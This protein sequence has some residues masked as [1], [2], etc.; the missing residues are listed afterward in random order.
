[1]NL[2]SYH[3]IF[4]RTK[5]IGRLLTAL[6]AFLIFHNGYGQ[7]NDITEVQMAEMVK[8]HSERLNKTIAD[9]SALYK[10]LIKTK[11]ILEQRQESKLLAK[12]YQNLGIW[13][14]KNISIDSVAYYYNKAALTYN[15]IGLPSQEAEIYLSLEDAYKKRSDYSSAMALDFKALRI[16]ENI[17]DQ[18]GIAKVYTRLCDIL[19]YQQEYR[20]GAEYCQ[21]AIII[22]SKLDQPVELAISYRYKADNLLI[23]K[24][25][26]E[27]L[28]NINQAI[29]VLEDANRSSVELAPNFNTRG[30]IYKYQERYKDAIEEYTRCYDIAKANNNYRGLISSLGNIGHVYRLQEKYKKALPYTLEA[31][32]LIKESGNTQNL[33]EN[34]M[35]TADSYKAIGDFEKSLTYER[36]FSK[37]KIENLS[38]IIDQLESELQIK[39]ETEKKDQTIESQEAKLERQKRIQQL[40][41]G[42]AFLL[43]VLLIGMYFYIRNNKKKRIALEKLNNK[44]KNKQ[45]QLEN[46]NSKLKASLKELK[47]TQEQLIQ[48]EKMAS[49]GELTAGIAHEIQNPLNFVNNFSEVS[50]ELIDEMREEL[51]NGDIDEAK[52]IANDVQQNL[53]KITHHGKRADSIVKGMLQHSRNSAGE[54]EYVDLNKL[55]DEY[56]RLA[57]HGLRA[58][59]KSFNANLIT[60]FE[61]TIPQIKIVPQEIGRVILNLFTNAFYAVDE[62]QKDLKEKNIADYTPTVTVLTR[63]DKDAIYI[64]VKDNGNGIPE[65][66]TKK[67]FDPF[68]TTKPTGKGTGLGLSMSYDIIKSHGG[69]LKLNTNQGEFTEFKINLPLK[70]N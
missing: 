5:K 43:I 41:F 33:A 50:S 20:E 18:S 12:S 27:A 62:K 64:T 26:E 14:D 1:M 23:L 24:E 38:T 58:K 3:L 59:D 4:Y 25:Y 61:D 13:Q 32:E 17:E 37:E 56:M 52:E 40:Y 57:Y 35:H 29:K 54:K 70:T 67:V 6:F 53:E 9:S 65:A 31:I 39:Y 60:D 10:D 46:S 34:Y 63:N 55:T 44:I 15:K 69:L 2:S 19:Y 66:F 30:N 11:N 49:L 7:E 42:I 48:S 22:Q 45:T 47:T 51:E 68:F 36:L 21:K 16:F 28:N 8:Q